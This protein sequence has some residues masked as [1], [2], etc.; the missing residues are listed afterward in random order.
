MSSRALI[1]S[2]T[3]IR[4]PQSPRVRQDYTY[5][6]IFM[7]NGCRVAV[8]VIIGIFTRERNVK[9]RLGKLRLRPLAFSIVISLILSEIILRIATRSIP[10]Y[11]DVLA[12]ALEHPERLYAPYA[13][14]TYNVHDLYANGG[15]VTMRISANRF[16]EPEP[17]G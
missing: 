2:V 15:V 12:N 6:L 11:A 3:D 7:Q 4:G 16:I 5:A 8:P 1:S 14:L 10:T 13:Q 17:H 9:G